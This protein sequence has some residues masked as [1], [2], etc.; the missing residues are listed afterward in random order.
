MHDYTITL[1]DDLVDAAW[2][3]PK[4]KPTATGSLLRG[5]NAG[6]CSRQI[7]FEAIG[8]K[9][10]HLIPGNVLM[11]FAVGNAFHERIQKIV[12]EKLDAKIEVTCTY[13]PDLSV[14]GHADFVYTRDFEYEGFPDADGETIVGEIKTLSGYGWGLAT[15][16]IKSDTPGPKVE[17]CLQAG[18]YAS[19]PTIGSHLV[20]MVYVDKDKH[21]I[22]EW[23]IDTEEE[24]L[25][26]NMS[27]AQMVERELDR[28]AGII[29]Q[30]ES[31]RLP[32]R[33]IPGYGLVNKVPKHGAPGTPW[34]C[35]YCKF[36]E[37]CAILPTESVNLGDPA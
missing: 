15:G 2:E 18:I 8:A 4:P 30:I 31:N 27:L 11:A 33:F 24:F 34:N 13:E 9:P 7:A 12:V 10:D 5:S 19:S 20:H 3:Q 23:L 1:I 36:R 14:S 6:Q 29:D 17:H 26:T 25:A 21:G 16:R 37:S 28:F 35:G 32:A 22:A